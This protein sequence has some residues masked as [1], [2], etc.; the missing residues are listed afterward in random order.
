MR[1]RVRNPTD[2]VDRRE[3]FLRNLSDADG[4]TTIHDFN[5]KSSYESEC[6]CRLRPR[7]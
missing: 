7:S 4:V 2:G 5:G 1:L 6:L 3:S